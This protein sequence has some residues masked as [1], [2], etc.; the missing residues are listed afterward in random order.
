MPA[1]L[2]GRAIFPKTGSASFGNDTCGSSAESNFLTFPREKESAACCGVDLR[3][4]MGAFG[5]FARRGP[6]EQLAEKSQLRQK[7]PR[8]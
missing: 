1:G 7:N 8:G 2:T 3:S 6:T 4:T 5:G